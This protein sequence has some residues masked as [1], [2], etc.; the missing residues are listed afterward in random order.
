[1]LY[2]IVD[3]HV[4]LPT[5]REHHSNALLLHMSFFECVVKKEGEIQNVNYSSGEKSSHSKD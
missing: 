5:I 1:M 2:S 4:I 3:C